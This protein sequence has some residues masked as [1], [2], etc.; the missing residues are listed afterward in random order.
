MPRVSFGR[1]SRFALLSAVAL[2]ASK[3]AQADPPFPLGINLAGVTDYSTEIIFV[4][5][6]KASRPWSSQKEG[7]AYGEGG[8]LDVDEKT[9]WVKALAP[10]Q[11]AEALMFVDMPGR[12]P[13]GKYVVTWE[14]N[15]EIEFSEAA[16][17]TLTRSGSE[18]DVNP[19]LQHLALRVRKTD[20]KKPV[21]N[22]KVIKAENYKKAPTAFLPA[23]LK[24]YEGF[25]V[26][27][28]MDWQR[29][30]NSKQQKWSER[31]RPDAPTQASNDGVAIEICIDLSNTLKADPWLCI[32]HLADDDYVKNFAQLVKNRLDPKRKVYVEYSNETWNTMFEQAKYCKEK[33]LALGLSTNE[34]EAQLRFSAQR[35]VEIFK[36]FEQVFGGKD[37]LVRVISTHG[38]NPWTGT[39]AMD[40]KEAHK[41][42]DAIA[43]APYFGNAYGDPKTADK[44]AAMSIDEL[45]DGCKKMIADNRKTNEKYMEEAKKRGLKLM[46]YESG[47][48]LVG[49]AGAENNEKLTKLFHEANRHPRMK[50]L[51]QEDLKNWQEVGGDTYCAFSSVGKYTKWGAWGLLEHSNQ[52]TSPKFE[53]IREFIAAGKKK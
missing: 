12:I 33:G 31:P 32:P 18:I 43:I 22:I 35:S 45:L 34:Y 5:A 47:Q 38:A 28:F 27:R 52:E 42:A 6:F 50:E 17:A 15:G 1:L 7:A 51:Y 4:D 48:H 25:Q 46:A 13:G 8:K 21:K 53:A 41:S 14:G 37:R 10:S 24:R 16:R 23:F 30:N 2:F 19:N 29:T 20:P 11:F 49:Y 9:G 36:I 40:W 39:T 44:V 3:P 26:I